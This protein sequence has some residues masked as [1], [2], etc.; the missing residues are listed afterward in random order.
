VNFILD[1]KLLIE[2]VITVVDDTIPVVV[3][4]LSLSK[5]GRNGQFIA[6]S[7][8]IFFFFCVY[9]YLPRCKTKYILGDQSKHHFL[10]I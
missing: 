1:E 5:F 8:L 6:C 2:D 10:G 9:G 7:G 4:G 3:C